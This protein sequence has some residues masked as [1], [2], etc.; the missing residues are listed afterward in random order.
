MM[1]LRAVRLILIASL[2]CSMGAH[3][4]VLQSIAWAKMSATLSLRST[5]D[6]KHPCALCLKLKKAAEQP[7][8]ALNA[9]RTESQLEALIPSVEKLKRGRISEWPLHPMITVLPDYPR[10]HDSP[11]PKNHF[12]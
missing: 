8:S 9:S 1:R 11:P 3:L 10:L 12:L 2:F 4:M 5:L 6:G 7:S